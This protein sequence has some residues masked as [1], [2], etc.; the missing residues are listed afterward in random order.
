MKK[1]HYRIE[2]L[3]YMCNDDPAYRKLKTSYSVQ[4]KRFWFM[5]WKYTGANF[6]SVTF[7]VLHCRLLKDS[8]T[9][10]DNIPVVRWSA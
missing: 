5:P 8:K 1:Y 7:L 3:T 9:P 4:R 10:A 6:T 2:A